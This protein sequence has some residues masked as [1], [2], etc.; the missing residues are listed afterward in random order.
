MDK[1]EHGTVIRVQPTAA[2]VAVPN[3]VLEEPRMSWR[4]KGVWAYLNSRPEGWQVRESDLLKRSTD[5]RHAM[6]S[7]IQE[8]ESCGYLRR[9]PIRDG[10]RF[11][12][13]VYH[14]LLP[15][16]D[17]PSSVLPPSV[18]PTSEDRPHNNTEVNKTETTN[19]Q[20]AGVSVDYSLDCSQWVS[21][22]PETP[23]KANPKDILALYSRERRA[24]ASESDLTTAASN[25]GRY[26]SEEGLLN[27]RYVMSAKRFLD[28]EWRGYLT[29]ES[30]RNP[31]PRLGADGLRYI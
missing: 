31:E 14:L 28:G 20:G 22:Y 27:S 19:T 11:V 26:L 25:Y 16:T 30:E 2:W 8:L 29:W 24:G 17:S 4:A 21:V 6:R 5:G 13:S 1:Q 12:G 7:A 3:A 9:D 18:F 10:G 15:R 23:W